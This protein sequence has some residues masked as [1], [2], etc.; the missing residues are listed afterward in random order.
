M[1][2]A[3]NHHHNIMLFAALQQTNMHTQIADFLAL[4]TSQG[5]YTA[6]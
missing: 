4:D 1:L 6:G 3:A 5:T 2:F